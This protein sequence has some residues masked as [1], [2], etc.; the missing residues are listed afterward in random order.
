MFFRRKKV[1]ESDTPRIK[2]TGREIESPE[3][4][5][6]RK[7]ILVIDDDPVIV[8]TLTL[9]LNTGGYQVVSAM[10]GSQ[11]ISIMHEQKPDM[12]LVDVG[13]PPDLAGGA[14]IAQWDGF[15]VTRWIQQVNSKKI[16]TIIISGTNKP[17][18]PKQARA[19]GAEGFL[20]KPIDNEFLLSAI[21]TALSR[22]PAGSNAVR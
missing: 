15:Q 6:P 12:M 17:E 14:N 4:T 22:K 11:A 9:T 8:K 2:L 1:A 19:V 21:A 18:Y 5:A 3:T 13:L 7:R 16:P 20:P 10:D